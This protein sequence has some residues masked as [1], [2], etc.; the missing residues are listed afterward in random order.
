MIVFRTVVMF[1]LLASSGAAAQSVLVPRTSSADA[2]TQGITV[3]GHATATAIPDRAR[4]TVQVFG[5]V[6]A[7]PAAGSVPLDD[8]A[9]AL[10][11]ALKANGVADAHEVLP[12][13]NLNT[14]SVVPAIVGTVAKPTRERLEEIARNVVKAIPDRFAP[15]F[16]NAQV[17]VA[18]FVDDCDAAE[19]RAERDAYADAKARATR[20][21]SAA[22]VRLGPVIAISDAQSSLPPGCTAKPDAGENGPPFINI[23]NGTGAYGPLVVPI[24]VYETVTFAI[25]RS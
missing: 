10:I 4:V 1:V 24:T 25:A 20:L 6:G 23:G 5:S 19:A 8:A 17:Q 2:T 15:A 12:L 3:S 14:R 21:A 7:A 9:N 11:D 22:G 13:A 18:L 16:A